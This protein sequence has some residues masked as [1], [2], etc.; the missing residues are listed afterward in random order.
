MTRGLEV[1][2]SA[3]SPLAQIYQPMYF[4]SE[5]EGD[6]AGEGQGYAE[7]SGPYG[8]RR[9]LSSMPRRETTTQ[10]ASTQAGTQ[11]FPVL[12]ESP[13]EPPPPSQGPSETASQVEDGGSSTGLF[14]KRFDRLE[15]RQKRIED[16][17]TH[18]TASLRR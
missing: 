4:G 7:P 18:L 2:Q 14:E 6:P 10:S 16:M 17:L 9:R 12:S 5:A 11:R 15:N 13:D 8:S 1:A 3:P